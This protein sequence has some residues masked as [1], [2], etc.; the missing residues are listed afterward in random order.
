MIDCVC[1]ANALLALIDEQYKTVP[2]ED[3]G[4]G[5]DQ[6][7]EEPC[8]KLLEDLSL[9]RRKIADRNDSLSISSR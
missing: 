4:I 3:D 1:V 9:E 2:R 6:D 5:H 7:H 8:Q